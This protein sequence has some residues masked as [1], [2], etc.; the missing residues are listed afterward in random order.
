MHLFYFIFLYI[1]KRQKSYEISSHR[2]K[3]ITNF[4]LFFYYIYLN[5]N[6]SYSYKELKKK[7]YKRKKNK[8]LQ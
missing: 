5:K 1:E 8:N 3:Y 7:F 4:I 2:C 6:F